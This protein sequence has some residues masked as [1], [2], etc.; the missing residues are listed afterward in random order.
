MQALSEIPV[1][2]VAKTFSQLK[3]EEAARTSSSEQEKLARLE[4][5]AILQEIGALHEA[6]LD[7]QVRCYF[8]FIVFFLRL[9]TY[10]KA[11]FYRS[12]KFAKCQC[13]FSNSSSYF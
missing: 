12:P 3:V 7:S 4:S 9:D 11:F 6:H 1:S 5:H 13:T 10:Q 8:I 2:H